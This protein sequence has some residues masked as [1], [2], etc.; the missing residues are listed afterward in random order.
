M[1]DFL[2]KEGKGQQNGSNLNLFESHPD[3]PFFSAVSITTIWI[4]A[5]IVQVYQSKPITSVSR[6]WPMQINMIKLDLWTGSIY[7]MIKLLKM[8]DVLKKYLVYTVT[9]MFYIF[10]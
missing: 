1:R 8:A 4:S 10:K 6:S 5:N 2:E 7:V 3:H 9:C